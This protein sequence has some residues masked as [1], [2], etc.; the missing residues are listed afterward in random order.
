MVCNGEIIVLEDLDILYVVV[1]LYKMDIFLEVDNMFW[2]MFSY[3]WFL[4]YFLGVCGKWE[5]EYGRR[6]NIFLFYRY[7]KLFVNNLLGIK[8]Y[9]KVIKFRNKGCWVCDL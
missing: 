2:K 5:E 8:F 3:R 7:V 6:I 4:F 1:G 9:K